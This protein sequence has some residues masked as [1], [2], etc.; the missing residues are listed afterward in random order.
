LLKSI[1]SNYVS[2]IHKKNRS[3]FWEITS[4]IGGSGIGKS[5]FSFETLNIIKNYVENKENEC[6][7]I[8]QKLRI[9]DEPIKL[10]K[11]F[12]KRIL[13]EKVIEIFIKESNEDQINSEEDID[14][15]LSCT[16]STELLKKET[17]EYVSVSK[18][19]S[20]SKEKIKPYEIINLIKKKYEIKEND[21]T[22]IWRI[23]E[24][25][26]VALD[27]INYKIFLYSRKPED[28]RST[29]LYKYLITL[30]DL[31]V[32]ESDNNTF[33]IPIISGTSDRPIELCVPTI[34]YSLN[35]IYL[36]I[37]NNN[38]VSIIEN[39]LKSKDK[40]IDFSHESWKSY[41]S[42]FG[43]VFRILQCLAE[44]LLESSKNTIDDVRDDLKTTIESFYKP[45]KYEKMFYFILLGTIER[46]N[47]NSFEDDKKIEINRLLMEGSLFL[48][49][50]HEIFL[51]LIIIQILLK[52]F[53]VK[54][55]K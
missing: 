6:I 18:I 39:Y 49:D 47:I 53:N 12:K 28:K 3:L 33:I 11:N 30:M 9:E 25:Q 34:S 32:C 40:I 42:S 46:W 45:K 8:F 7:E 52:K 51:P 23:D 29:Q 37:H 20:L 10:F 24:I 2:F 4:I 43:G 21:L 38:F 5:R 35:F 17:Q 54:I 22:I 36:N 19:K 16:L 50:N 41:I 44:Q 31:V 27:D 26:N 48:T 55:K 1:F 13:K 14:F 15:H